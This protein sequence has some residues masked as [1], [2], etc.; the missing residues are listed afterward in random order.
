MIETN[1]FRTWNCEKCGGIWIGDTPTRSCMECGARRFGYQTEL[2]EKER[3]T[4]G[5]E[6]AER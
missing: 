6:D 2:T 5:K 1:E 4:D 3:E